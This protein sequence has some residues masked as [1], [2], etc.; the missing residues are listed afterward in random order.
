ML[1]NYIK[2]AWR[3]LTKSKIYS[4]IN[5]LGLAIGLTCF[6]LISV[7]VYHELTYDRYAARADNIYRVHLS[8]TGNGDVAVYPDVD[9]AVGDGMK[10]AYPEVIASTRITPASD[11]VKFE[12]RQ[13]KEQ[14]L[15]FADSNFLNMFSIHLIAGNESD[16]LVQPNS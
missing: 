14:H 16:A 4:T 5:I 12:D 6:M 1:R 3:N 9:V 10:M 7:F 2:T 8:A 13:F 11:F 15:A